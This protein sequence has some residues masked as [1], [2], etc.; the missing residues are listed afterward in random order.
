VTV[1]TDDGFPASRGLEWTLRIGAF[2]C[3]AGHGVFGIITKQ[4]WVP[5]FGVVGIGRETA[6][7]LMPL[8]GT[9]DII[10]GCSMLLRPRPSVAYWMVA[11]AA[12]TALLRPLSGEPGWEAVERA[13][14][15]G[16]PAALAVLIVTPRAFADAFRVARFRMT[17]PQALVLA[18]W[19]L[20]L[21]V[22]L[23]MI[24][25]GA[26]GVIGK[27]SITA[28]FGSIFPADIAPAMTVYAGWFEIALGALVLVRPL[29]ALL[30]FVC[31]WKLATESLFVA[32]GA[33]IWEVVERGGSY[34]API[35]LALLLSVNPYNHA[36]LRGSVAWL[37]HWSVRDCRRDWR[38][39][40]GRGLSRA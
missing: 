33:P 19:G 29:P 8:V 13:G 12:W 23:L 15:Y 17:S 22:A 3:F 39:R 4:A 32:A 21:T 40:H 6:F 10:L 30:L 24:G 7:Q 16:V 18:R 38:R 31:A 5:Y 27:R 35:A 20:T 11:W 1:R 36:T 37:T 34:T 9:V 2:M 26:L 28:N 25:H 14:N